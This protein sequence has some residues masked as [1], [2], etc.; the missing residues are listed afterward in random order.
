MSK[1]GGSGF[2]MS[3]ARDAQNQPIHPELRARDGKLFLHVEVNA[4]RVLQPGQAPGM[5]DNISTALDIPL[6]FQTAQGKLSIGADLK[7]AELQRLQAGGLD[8]GKLVPVSAITQLVGD[9]ALSQTVDPA[10]W[11]GARFDRVQVGSGGDLTVVVG[12]TPST[13]DWAAQALK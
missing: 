8:L 9:Q 4:Q 2:Q 1:A 10:G 13:V 3:W 6:Q 5:L 11:G 12:T 7:G